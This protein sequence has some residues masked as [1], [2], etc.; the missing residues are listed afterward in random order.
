MSTTRRRPGP[1]PT[2]RTETLWVRVDPETL[3]RLDLIRG[4]VSRSEWVYHM[5]KRVMGEYQHRDDNE[6]Y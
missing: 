1:A 2:G 6:R 3:A 5:L 4:D